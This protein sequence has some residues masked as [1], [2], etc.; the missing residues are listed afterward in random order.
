MDTRKDIQGYT[1]PQA[2]VYPKSGINDGA[3]FGSNRAGMFAY[4]KAERL[5]YA[6]YLVTNSVPMAEPVR[7]AV[8]DLAQSI[9]SDILELRQGFRGQGE[10]EVHRSVSHIGQ[11]ISLLNL[12]YAGGYL[13][14][15][16]LG[17]LSKEY[18]NL[19][20]FLL[21]ARDSADAEDI[22]LD[23][24]LVSDP[25]FRREEAPQSL[26]TKGHDE[27]EESKG[28]HVKETRHVHRASR[29][30]KESRKKVILSA[31]RDLGDA[32][33]SDISQVVTDCSEKTVQREL[34]ALVSD[35]VLKKSGERRWTKYRLA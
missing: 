27:S 6:T 29:T 32:Q 24:A 18:E 5:I 9:L 35:G 3:V 25:V 17:I 7:H 33:V 21:S 16:N 14:P 30:E 23:P 1:Q 22:S 13:S 26:S 10:R 11:M 12:L 19:A 28:H 34:Q 20:N 15:G 4:R 2:G 31:V 8:R